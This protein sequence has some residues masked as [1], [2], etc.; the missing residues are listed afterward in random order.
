MRAAVRHR[1]S[2][3]RVVHARP[4]SAHGL[5]RDQRIDLIDAILGLGHR[6]ALP[7]LRT[8]PRVR[9]Y[10][11][12]GQMAFTAGAHHT[13]A[14][15]G[16]PSCIGEGPLVLTAL[17]LLHQCVGGERT[18]EGCASLSWALAS[19]PDVPFGRSRARTRESICNTKTPHVQAPKSATRY[20]VWGNDSIRST[21]TWGEAVGN[22]VLSAGGE[23]RPLKRPARGAY[24]VDGRRGHK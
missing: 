12:P 3:S 19:S 2:S 5:A 7:A 18:T 9:Y 4:T 15:A 20:R 17:L 24:A 6:A 1:P 23:V 10:Q 14:A 11:G 16:F 22:E 8:F 13:T 21:A